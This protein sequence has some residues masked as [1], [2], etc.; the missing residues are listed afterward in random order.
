MFVMVINRDVGGH[1]AVTVQVLK[2][3][4]TSAV[5]QEA[6]VLKLFLKNLVLT[7]FN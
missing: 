3:F 6:A 4:P 5:Q 1:V 2:L 7:G